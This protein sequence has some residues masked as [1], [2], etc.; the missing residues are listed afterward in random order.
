M[1]LLEGSEAVALEV[2]PD[3]DAVRSVRLADGSSLR[4][5]ALML[6]SGAWLRDLL[7]VPVAPIKGQM[8]ALRPPETSEPTAPSSLLR[9][10]LFAQDCYIIPRRD[11]R[12][13]VGATVEPEAGFS[14]R[15]TAG[16]V[17]ELLSSAIATDGRSDGR[18][19]GCHSGL[20]PPPLPRGQGRDGSC[21]D[22]VAM[23][24]GK[25]IKSIQS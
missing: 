10:V 22:T 2:S 8:L 23:P 15:S 1:R 20:Q 21:N 24:V 11:G 25:A 12:I 17:H 16:G 18:S 14:M 9:R 7:P 3:G 4:A 6:C 13:V 5:S 19:V